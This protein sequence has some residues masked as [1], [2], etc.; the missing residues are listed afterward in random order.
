MH[1]PL[2]LEKRADVVFGEVFRCAMRAVDHPDLPHGRQFSD[3][4][5]LLTDAVIGQRRHMQH[6]A[7][8]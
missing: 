4:R 5:Q 6:I 8:P 7:G 3:C 1:F 2:S